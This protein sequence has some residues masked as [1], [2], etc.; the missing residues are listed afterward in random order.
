MS[1]PLQVIRLVAA[2]SSFTALPLDRGASRHA[3]LGQ[4]DIDGGNESRQEEE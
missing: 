4:D 2:V 3:E 1:W